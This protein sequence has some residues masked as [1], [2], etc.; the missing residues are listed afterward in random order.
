MSKRYKNKNSNRKKSKVTQFLSNLVIILV[1]VGVLGFAINMLDFGTNDK[2]ENVTV[3]LV[4]GTEWSSDSSSY[5]AWCWNNSGVPEG[6]FVL[7][8][9]KD[10]D[11]VFEFNVSTE[12]SRML[13]V[14]LVPE[15]TELGDDW[16]NKRAQTDNLAVPTDKKVYYHQYANEWSDSTD[17]LFNVTTSD[18]AV[19]LDTSN[20]QRFKRL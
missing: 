15:A 9:D 11:C 12:Y 2:V 6:S 13:F 19:Y 10:E 4:P 7:V 3:Y 1:L 14:D 16:K 5:G 17:M 20:W 18:V 8:T